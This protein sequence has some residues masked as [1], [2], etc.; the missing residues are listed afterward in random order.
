MHCLTCVVD[1]LLQFCATTTLVLVEDD[2][3]QFK[4]IKGSNN[5]SIIIPLIYHH[6]DPLSGFPLYAV[7][8][9]KIYN[10]MCP[11]PVQLRRKAPQSNKA[12]RQKAPKFKRLVCDAASFFG[13]LRF[14]GISILLHS[15]TKIQ[16]AGAKESNFPCI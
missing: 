15:I 8:I 10:T 13:Y 14:E 12:Q 4:F 3:R 1:Y 2:I 7:L 6:K 16:A 11:V 5:N 9:L